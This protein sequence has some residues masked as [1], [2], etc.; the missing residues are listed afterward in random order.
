MGWSPA[1][2]HA[3]GVHW[4]AGNKE[5]QNS[6]EQHTNSKDSFS[7]ILSKFFT[8][9]W[10]IFVISNFWE[11]LAQH[12]QNHTSNPPPTQEISSENLML[13]H[14]VWP[15][16]FESEGGSKTPQSMA[17][18]LHACKKQHGW[19][20]DL[21]LAEMVARSIEIGGAVASGCPEAEEGTMNPRTSRVSREHWCSSLKKK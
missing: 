15:Q 21:L 7:T 5:R 20:Q 6:Q 11:L 3:G 14:I 17:Y 8:F 4:Q 16:G 1:D 19:N 2:H 12:S 9:S 10:K 18:I 13:W